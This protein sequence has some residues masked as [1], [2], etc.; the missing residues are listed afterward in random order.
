MKKIKLLLCIFFLNLIT[1]T[2]V[3]GQGA[4][5]C[6]SVTV[7]PPATIC[8]GNCTSLNATLVTS[9]QTTSYS[10]A[11]IPYVPYSYTTG[12]SVLVSTDDIWSSVENIGFNF[13]YFG[14]TFSQF[15]IGA[16]GQITFDLS[17]AGGYDG[18]Q[19]T[20]PLPST[21]DMPGNTISCPFR[22]IDPAISA[23]GEKISYQIY[24]TAPCRALVVSWNNVPL[25]DNGAGTCDGTPNST[26]QVVLY[27]NTNFIDVYI[28]NSYSCSA[29]NGG[30]GTI[31]IQNANATVAVFPPGRNN[32]TFSV[33]GTPEA[34][35]FTPTGVPSYNLN[36]YQVG[37]ATSLGTTN[38]ITVC[39][40]TTT[41]YAAVM[42]SIDCDGSSFNKYDTVQVVVTPSPTVTAIASPTV[43]CSGSS[44]TLTA[45]GASS[46]TW[47]P[48]GST[49]NPLT[50]T[51]ATTTTYTVTGT[52][53]GC[54]GTATVQVIV[55]PTVITA[56]ASPTVLCPGNSSTLTATGPVGT[57]YSWS[58]GGGTT[59]SI[60]V[61]PGATTTYTVTGTNGGCTGTATVTVTISSTLVLT[62]NSSPTSICSGSSSTLTATG[63]AGTA[64][65]WSD[66]STTNP[67]VVSP[68]TT[69]TYTVTGTNG[70][71][72]GTAMVTVTINPLP[73]ITITGNNSICQGSNTV[74]TANG[75]VSYSWNPSTGLSSSTVANPTVTVATNTSYTVTGTDAN[76][77]S[78][79]VTVMVI[80]NPLPTITVNSPTIC[81]GTSATLT[82]SGAS[83]YS[84]NTS[85][86]SNPLTVSPTSTT[87]Y[88]VTGTDANGCTNSAIAVV[89][90]NPKPIIDS[91]NA[92][93]P[94]ICKGTLGS[95][96]G[97]TVSGGTSPYAYSW[98]P[99]GQ[100]TA[101]ATGLVAG[102]YT[103]TVTDANGCTSTS[104][105]YVI[106][107][108]LVTA[109]FTAN[110][111]T[112]TVPLAVN[113]T[114]TSTG[115]SSYEWNLGNGTTTNSVNPSTTYGATGTYN[116][117]LIA[118]NSDGCTDTAYG[119]IDVFGQSILIVP[120]VFS[121]NGDG[122]N[123][124]F[125]V[126]ASAI[127]SF[128][129]KIFDRW[130]IKLYEWYDANGGWDGR[131]SGGVEV[132]SGTYYY[133]INATGADGKQ[134]QEKGYLTLLR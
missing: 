74:L 97:I 79:T 92:L 38:P 18:W 114:N 81:G 3:F 122:K 75:G 36:W 47:S 83:S 1:S 133:L 2:F 102:S 9:N 46:Y 42:K 23:S 96:T 88:T 60:S 76:G 6:P 77:C 45:S 123:D 117:E 35:R 127:T 52:N 48:G 70:A 43:L 108:S 40:T 86:T 82:A 44:S 100:T 119:T 64:Y 27:E 54:S 63:P 111:N 131:T 73:T 26:F 85:S 69:T 94:P 103:L 11:S 30:F 99:T 50:A 59:S 84:W 12:T 110:P 130:G 49:S 29:W 101:N 20:T 7:A 113:F 121:P 4:P 78:G 61:T 72:T 33:N 14:N 105:P 37:N 95:I 28:E 104:G 34:W 51:P 22:D 10:V 41:S 106:V 32:T 17:N 71:C 5:A 66:G 13:C 90:V 124:V 132:P 120:N 98:S 53:G 65:S 89:T 112:G 62:A 116:V 93:F 56:N 8:S 57:T 118:T 91:L 21:T 87:S 126:Q 55:G 107:N 134:Y 80:V 129:G 128:Q 115:A 19:N 24:G 109:S 125:K 67:T 58:P 39:P 31:G 15:V 68:V 25:F 16:N